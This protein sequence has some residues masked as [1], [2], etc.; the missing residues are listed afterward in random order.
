MH[1]NQSNHTKPLIRKPLM[2][3]KIQHDDNQLVAFSKSK[4]VIPIPIR[5]P[6]WVQKVVSPLDESQIKLRKKIVSIFKEVKTTTPRQQ[7][8]KATNP[9]RV[10]VAIKTKV[11]NVPPVSP[12]QA[13]SQCCASKAVTPNCGKLCTFGG[14]SDKTLVQAVLTNQCPNNQLGLVFDCA[15][16]G[17]NHNTCCL[18][19]GVHLISNGMCMSFCDGNRDKITDILQYFACLQVFD[20]IKNCYASNMEKV[21]S[22]SSNRLLM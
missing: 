18:D 11:I 14:I 12:D 16:H 10:P 20:K 9:T 1:A 2:A 8:A 17:D 22:R 19:N 5:P 3:K 7:L 21:L 6:P 13:F 4:G 15:N